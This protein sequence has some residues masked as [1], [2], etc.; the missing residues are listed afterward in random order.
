MNH[1]IFGFHPGTSIIHRLTGT[2]KL[3]IFLALTIFGSLSFDLRYLI[4]LSLVALVALY[5]AK[6]KW[7]DVRTIVWLVTIFA[8]INLILIYVFA[9]QYGVQLFG[10]K[11]VLFGSGHYALTFEQ[12]YYEFI[13]F[14]KY[15]FAVPLALVFLLT[16]NPSEFAA[17]L[18]RIG[19]SYR[20]AYAVALALRY[21]PDIQVSYQTISK[22][23]QARGHDL[24]KKASLW[25]RL[26]GALGI[27]VPLMFASLNQIDAVSQAMDLRRFGKQKRRTWYYAQSF[28]RIDWLALGFAV[29]LIALEMYLLWQN[30]GRFW[31]PF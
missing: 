2:T 30:G 11:T 6:I 3:V 13:V 17:G 24:S 10:S 20:V 29:A 5:V 21:I 4:L 28:A 15:L 16:T 25:K 22:V 18:N 14:V 7:A 1:N 27:M 12:L 8:V 19:I 23:Q 31:Y 9:P 26:K